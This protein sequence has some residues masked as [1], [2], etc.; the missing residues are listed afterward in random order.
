MID[1]GLP[2]GDAFRFAG[3]AHCVSVSVSELGVTANVELLQCA[4]GQRFHDSRASYGSDAIVTNRA[5]P[6]RSLGAALLARRHRDQ[7]AHVAGAGHAAVRQRIAQRG[8]AA[9]QAEQRRR[10]LQRRSARRVREVLFMRNL[11]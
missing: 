8:G 2:F 9:R 3:F 4:R 10:G 6:A 5:R 7:P 1:D 11:E